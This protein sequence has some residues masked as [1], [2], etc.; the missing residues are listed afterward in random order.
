MS[1]KVVIKNG[2]TSY[3][4]KISTDEKLP[5]SICRSIRVI[6]V[7][8]SP[9]NFSLETQRE[10]VDMKQI[11][12]IGTEYFDRDKRLVKRSTTGEYF[13]ETNRV[14][15]HRCKTAVIAYETTDVKGNIELFVN[16]N[17]GTAN[18]NL[19]AMLTNKGP[20]GKYNVTIDGVYLGNIELPFMYSGYTGISISNSESKYE[21]ILLWIEGDNRVLE[22]HLIDGKEII[23]PCTVNVMT[24]VGNDMYTYTNHFP[25]KKLI[26]SREQIPKICD[27]EVEIKRDSAGV[28]ENVE[29]KC[30]TRLI[31][32][33][34][35][36]LLLNRKGK[37]VAFDK[38]ESYH[39]FVMFSFMSDKNSSFIKGEFQLL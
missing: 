22:G 23:P 10:K 39:N 33:K 6:A 30:V 24:G 36:V 26:C 34:R 2:R 29:L 8:G 38:Y 14:K 3:S 28:A 4:D 12:H 32:R 21:E 25:T 11:T 1:R 27:I 35:V 18:K 7:D 17:V 20:S 16:I 15:L 5:F 37:K 19:Y 13:F 9:I 31:E